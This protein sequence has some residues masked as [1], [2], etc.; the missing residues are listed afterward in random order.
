MLRTT[1]IKKPDERQ[2]PLEM[3]T[4][5]F[6]VL[7]TGDR[8]GIYLELD[9]E[10]EDLDLTEGLG[11]DILD[12]AVEGMISAVEQNSDPSTLRQWEPTRRA[13]SGGRAM[14]A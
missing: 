14:A 12:M 6:G 7:E 3:R 11:D 4:V 9:V 2:H 8:L 10:H 1:S 5:N 13:R